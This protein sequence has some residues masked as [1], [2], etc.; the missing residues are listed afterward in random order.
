VGVKGRA[1]LSADH[2]CYA[3]CDVDAGAGDSK[4]PWQAVAGVGYSFQWGDVV[5]TWRDLDH[6]VKSGHPMESLAFS[7]PS[8]SAVFRR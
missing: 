2:N 7:G 1:A 8:I 3:P 5:A 4:L 6:E